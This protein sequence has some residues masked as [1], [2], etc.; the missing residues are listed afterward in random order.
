MHAGKDKVSKRPLSAGSLDSL[1]T[2]AQFSDLNEDTRRIRKENCISLEDLRNLVF[3][4]G[5]Y[6]NAGRID[7]FEVVVDHAMRIAEETGWQRLLAEFANIQGMNCLLKRKFQE[8]LALFARATQLWT[9]E[10]VAEE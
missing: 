4:V 5:H 8:A 9:E 10:G 3:G 1:E 2:L 7:D 6:R